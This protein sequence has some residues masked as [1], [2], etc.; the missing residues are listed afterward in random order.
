M[1]KN[2]SDFDIDVK[3]VADLL[4]KSPRT[5]RRWRT[6]GVLIEGIDYVWYGG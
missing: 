5:L 6:D 3:T 1:D 2:V 4:R